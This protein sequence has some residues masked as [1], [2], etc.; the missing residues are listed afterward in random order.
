MA[1]EIMQVMRTA[2]ILA[3]RRERESNVPYPLR[4]FVTGKGTICMF[5]RTLELLNGLHYDHIYVVVGYRKELFLK[6]SG[7]N[8]HF[9][10]NDKY[11]FTSS[12]GSLALVEPFIKDDFVL[13]ESDTFYERV[14]LEQLTSTKYETCFSI[15]E[16]SGSGDEAYVQTKNGFVEKVSKDIHQILHIDGEMIGLT[17]ISL[18]TLHRM[19]RSYRS[20]SNKWVNYEYLLLDAT[21][22]IDRPY[23]CFRNLIWGEVD[24]ERDFHKLQEE[25]YPKLRR[26]DN[27]YDS[28]N[29]FSCLHTIFPKDFRET[30]WKVEQIGGMSNKNF[31]VSSVKGDEYVLRIPGIGAEGMVERKNE[32]VNSLLACKLGL[33][34][35]ILYFDDNTGVKLTAFVHNA[36]T[37][38]S[39]TIQRMTNMRQVAMLLKTLHHSKVRFANEFNIFHEILRYEHL[40]KLANGIK[41]DGYDAVRGRVL[42]LEGYLNELG[43][44][45]CPTHNDLVAENF[46]CDGN[47]KV[48]LIDWEYSGMNDPMADIAALLL[49]SQFSEDNA[50]YFLA[51]YFNGEV[52]DNAKQ[53]IGVYQILWDFLWAIWTSIKEAQGDDFGTYGKM[54][55]TRAVKNLGKIGK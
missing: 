12:M 11:A 22:E 27:P 1:I 49:E 19:C 18:D 51:E 39:G 15:T 14:V 54:R 7:G 36:E 20:A 52:P 13:I 55:F 31:K 50:D 23:I 29:L 4:S 26:K 35:N 41:Y 25:V 8:V 48:W 44:N 34:P 53:K 3:A 45:I 21:R 47:G 46:L 38:N 33:S 17:K 10:Y 5:E 2:V 42:A 9:I 6:Y 43:V 40:L 37:L 24:N 28:D 32:D 30:D 16:E